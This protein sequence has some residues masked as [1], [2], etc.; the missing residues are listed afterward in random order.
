MDHPLAIGMRAPT[1]NKF[2]TLV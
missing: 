2:I 1:W